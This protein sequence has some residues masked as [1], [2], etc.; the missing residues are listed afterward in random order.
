MSGLRLLP[1]RRLAEP[2]AAKDVPRPLRRRRREL[3][4]AERGQVNRARDAVR[5]RPVPCTDVCPANTRAHVEASKVKFER[6]EHL[7]RAL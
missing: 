6:G 2:W 1:E 5:H 4:G 7:S 3:E